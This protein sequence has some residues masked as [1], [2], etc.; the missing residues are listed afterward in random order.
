SHLVYAVCG[1]GKTE[2]LFPAIHL[3]LQQGKRICLAA[4]RTDV[5]LEL[6]PR[7]QAA[8]PKTLIHTLYGGSPEQAGFP[9]L[10]LATTHQLYRFEK[11]FDFMIVDEAD[12][13]PYTMDAALQRAV[14]K[15]KKP[16]APVV[17]VSA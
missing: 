1:A 12:A 13:F 5:V 9:L 14:E 15:A 11:A 6:S 4:P 16:G 10:V 3:A 17:Y 7:L 8:F 2:L